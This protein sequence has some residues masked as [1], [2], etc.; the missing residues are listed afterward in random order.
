MAGI[1]KHRP[2]LRDGSGISREATSVLCKK[3]INLVGTAKLPMSVVK[4]Y[5]KVG[6]PLII[7]YNWDLSI[8][9]Y[10]FQRSSD[11]NVTSQVPRF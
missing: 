11:D 4:Q 9:H 5:V 7:L 1:A 6:Q 3:L 10:F 2:W 8:K